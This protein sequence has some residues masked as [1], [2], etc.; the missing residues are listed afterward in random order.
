[1]AWRARRDAWL[2]VAVGGLP[3]AER[4]ELV[5]VAAGKSSLV[6]RAEPWCGVGSGFVAE[7]L[8]ARG[9]VFDEPEPGAADLSSVSRSEAI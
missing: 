1:M 7:V 5:S 6:N 9:V 3:A 4:A 8:A 2:R